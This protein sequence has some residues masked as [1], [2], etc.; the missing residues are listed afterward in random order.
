MGDLIQRII[1]TFNSI[2]MVAAT[3]VMAWATVVMARLTRRIAKSNHLTNVIAIRENMPVLNFRLGQ[4]EPLGWIVENVGKGTAINVLLTHETPTGEVWEPLRDYNTLQPGMSYRI[5]WI[6]QPY[7]FIAQYTDIYRRRYTSICEKNTNGVQDGWLHED[8]P[9]R[10][11]VPYWRMVVAG[12]IGSNNR[13]E[14][15]TG[16]V[17]SDVEGTTREGGTESSHHSSLSFTQPEEVPDDTTT[18]EK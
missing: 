14:S 3:V 11:K 2:I 18:D 17:P 7:K 5:T 9:Q 12:E 8:W 1:E 13:R 16:F 4:E 10:K 6:Q 15:P